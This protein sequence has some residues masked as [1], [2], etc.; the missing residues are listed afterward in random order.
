MPEAEPGHVDASPSLTSGF[1]ATTNALIRRSTRHAARSSQGRSARYPTL[2]YQQESYS[3]R[4]SGGTARTPRTWYPVQARV[5]STQCNRAPTGW[6][7]GRGLPPPIFDRRTSR[8][9]SRQD[10]TRL[11]LVPSR[12][13]FGG[14]GQRTH[15]PSELLDVS[16]F[17][18]P[19]LPASSAGAARS[20]RRRS[21]AAARHPG[22]TPSAATAHPPRR[23]TKWNRPRARFAP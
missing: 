19:R 23:R 22:Q 20:S 7:G 21:Q 6:S 9:S 16:A 8:R 11:Y 4:R 5:R 2:D 18:S 12:S 13:R 10:L 17:S 14:A 3:P 1:V 15:A